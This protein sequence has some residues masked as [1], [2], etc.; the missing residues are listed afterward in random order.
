MFLRS[1]SPA[2]LTFETAHASA[3]DGGRWLSGKVGLRL[4]GHG[5]TSSGANENA[6]GVASDKRDVAFCL[7]NW[8]ALH[9]K[10]SLVRKLILITWRLIWKEAG[11]RLQEESMP[12]S[13]MAWLYLLVS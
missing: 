9:E 10:V 12:V 3:G 1:H 2:F 7:A 4:V 11:W 5:H 6:C 13:H 8:P